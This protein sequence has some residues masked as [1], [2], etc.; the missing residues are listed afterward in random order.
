MTETTGHRLCG[1][2]KYA[3]TGPLNQSGHCHCESCR[4]QITSPMTSFLGVPNEAFKW[5]GEEPLP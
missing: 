2:M 4:R 3:F 1:A 5:T